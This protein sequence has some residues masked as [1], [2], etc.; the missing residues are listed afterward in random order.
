MGEV[1][2]EHFVYIAYRISIMAS[3]LF[4]ALY[5]FISGD[6]IERHVNIFRSNQFFR[7]IN[8][9]E[10]SRMVS[11]EQ[12]NVTITLSFIGIKRIYMNIF[13]SLGTA[14]VKISMFK[15]ISQFYEGIIF[16][17]YGSFVQNQ[18]YTYS[19]IFLYYDITFRPRV[20]AKQIIIRI[21]L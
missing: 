12:I 11:T 19:Y 21:E 5:L 2:T 14:R 15:T 9:P 20:K 3:Y 18:K 4:I 10:C 8:I 7:G 17:H 6:L 16:L 13:F 1:P